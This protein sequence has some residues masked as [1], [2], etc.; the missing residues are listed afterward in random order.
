MEKIPKGSP[1][2]KLI[3]KEYNI[4][5]DNITREKNYN[6]FI[7]GLPVTLERKDIFTILSKDFNGNYRYSATQKVDGIRLLLFANFKKDTG[8]RNITFIDRNNDFYTLKNKTRDFLP[9]F[10]GPKLLIDGELVTYSID[11]EVISATD[12]YVNIKMFS[13]MAFDILYGPSNI[14]YSGP[15]N[16]KRLNIGSEGA[17]AGPL[18]GKMWSYQQRYDI[19]YKLLVP[20]KINNNRPILSLHLKNVHGLYLK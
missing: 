19:L 13:F 11:N 6:K 12:N 17:M 1:E 9:N 5:I 10:N 4:V 16:Y 15:P 7:G 2:Y 20:N 18:G 3:E 14:E 8:Y